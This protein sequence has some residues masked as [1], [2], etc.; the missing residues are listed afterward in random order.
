MV[1]RVR[2][3]IV[4]ACLAVGL[5]VTAAE[6]R[7]A[8]VL[9][10]PSVNGNNVTFNWSATPGATGYRLDY[11]VVSAVYLGSLPVGLVTS[12]NLPGAPNGIFVIRVVAATAAGDLASNEITL[13]IPAPPAAPTGLVV[14]RNGTGLVA[15]WTPGSGGGAPSGYRLHA[16]SSPGGAPLA[17]LS[18]AIP[19]W[20]IGGGVPANTYHFR[21]VAFNAV[22]ESAPSN[23]VTVVMPVGGACD[24][25]PTPVLTTSAW[26][27]I[28]SASWT[29][30]TGAASYLFNYDGPGFNGQIPIGGGQTRLSYRGIPLGNWQFS[31]QATFA[32]GQ[33][34]GAGASTLVV[35]N[36]TLRLTPRAPD[37][38]SPTPPNYIRLP[39][40][41]SVVQQLAAQYPGEMRNSCGNHAFLFRVLAELRKE[42]K[43]WGLN[44]KRSIVGSMSEDVLDYNFGPEADE[45]TRNVHVVDFIAG[46]C[47]S[48]PGPAWIDQTVLFTTGAT[49]TLVPFIEAGYQP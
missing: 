26:G 10:A 9:A 30:I 33:A 48:N 4:A 3:R 21:A 29:P 44:W 35:D 27:N 45:G 43:R 1:L 37:P 36:S 8:P 15:L 49:W 20:G 47:G 13:R 40:R 7:Q 32:C 42:D 2:S 6:A 39:N 24:A 14:A 25:P 31:V 19:S 12:F 28:L 17:T 23:E 41:F 16:A 18:S 22:G 46:H 34:G 38:P 5:A 11:G